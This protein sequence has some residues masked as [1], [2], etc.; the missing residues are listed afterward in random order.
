MNRCDTLHPMRSSMTTL[1]RRALV[2]CLLAGFLGKSPDASRLQTPATDKVIAEADCTPAKLGTT[3]PT[4]AI[5]EPVSGVTL[6][7]PVWTAATATAP[8]QCAIDGSMAPV[9]QA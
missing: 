7:A 1:Q 8:A 4:S 6:K 9:D 3:I 2:A 5:K